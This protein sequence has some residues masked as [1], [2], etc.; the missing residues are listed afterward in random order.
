MA[1]QFYFNPYILD[2][3]P[4]P[5]RGFD[6]VQDVSEPRLR[7]YVTSRGAKTFFVRKRVHGKDKRI[8]IGNYPEIDID[9][10]REK[11]PMMLAE[12]VKKTPVRRRKI[13]FKQF[14]DLYLENKIH[15][16]EDSYVKLVRAINK[17]LESLF[18]KNINEISG[19]DIKNLVAKSMGLQSQDV[20]KNC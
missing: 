6:V 4:V 13:S 11:V 12:V 8:I 2:N 14:V 17:H 7:M 15:R 20:C 10:A 5:A 19:D 1:H 16:S 9:T 18:E 3:L